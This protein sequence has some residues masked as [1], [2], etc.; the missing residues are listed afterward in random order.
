MQLCYYDLILLVCTL[1]GMSV[2][3]VRVYAVYVRMY[4]NKYTCYLVQVYNNSN[5]YV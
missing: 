4:M 2:Y 5:I 1:S 3:G